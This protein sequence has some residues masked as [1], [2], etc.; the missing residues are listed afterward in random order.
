MK[1]LQ[2]SFWFLEINIIKYFKTVFNLFLYLQGIKIVKGW[3]MFSKTS[4]DP[5]C[6]KNIFFK[7]NKLFMFL[8]V[9]FQ[10]NR[11][12]RVPRKQGHI[13]WMHGLKLKILGCFHHQHEIFDR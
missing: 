13:F 3:I 12:F 9:V 1:F 8:L 5:C 4:G 11:K 7:N 10:I 6:L 2:T